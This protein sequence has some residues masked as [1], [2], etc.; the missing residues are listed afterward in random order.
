MGYHPGTG[1]YGAPYMGHS[2]HMPYGDGYATPHWDP[3]APPVA[4]PYQPSYPPPAQ[5]QAPSSHGDYRGGSA[6]GHGGSQ[7][8][9]PEDRHRQEGGEAHGSHASRARH[10]VQ[11]TTPS[12]AASRPPRAEADAV[13]TQASGQG[14]EDPDL[15]EEGAPGGDLEAGTRTERVDRMRERLMQVIADRGRE[16]EVLDKDSVSVSVDAAQF[17]PS[18]PSGNT[19]DVEPGQFSDEDEVGSLGR[20]SPVQ[21]YDGVQDDHEGE[22][23]TKKPRLSEGGYGLS[24]GPGTSGPIAEPRSSGTP[25]SRNPGNYSG[26]SGPVADLRN[27]GA[28]ESRNAGAPDSR[29]AGACSGVAGV[30]SFGVPDLRGS[31]VPELRDSA[32]GNFGARNR[33]SGAGFLDTQEPKQVSTPAEIANTKLALWNDRMKAVAAYHG[34]QSGPVEEVTLNPR[35]ASEGDVVV[36][37]EQ[38]TRVGLHRRVTQA[39]TEYQGLAEDL[40]KLKISPAAKNVN[41]S[42]LVPLGFPKFLEAADGTVKSDHLKNILS[43][44]SVTDDNQLK[45]KEVLFREVLAAQSLRSQVHDTMHCL[46]KEMPADDPARKCLLDC[47]QIMHLMTIKEVD[48][49]SSMLGSTIL[50]RRDMRLSKAKLT[51]EEKS[52]LRS[53]SFSSPLLMDNFHKEFV[54]DRLARRK[55]KHDDEVLNSQQQPPNFYLDLGGILQNQKM[56]L[57]PSK[58]K[59]GPKPHPKGAQGQ[60]PKSTPQSSS[61]GNAQAASQKKA[62]KRK[63]NWDDNKDNNNNKPDNKGRGSK[64]GRGRG[65]RGGRGAPPGGRPASK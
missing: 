18:P 46:I 37:K 63:G 7:G 24:G 27:S 48:S 61:Q 13:A 32:S 64:R 55:M 26:I 28:P 56:A 14:V 53:S 52:F 59:G 49:V 10:R 2:G 39:L 38:P 41:N 9:R 40:T 51:N 45:Q 42:F 43:E 11:R 58:A 4:P 1:G 23:P 16:S 54:D 34:V 30:G 8:Y 15:D 5:A 25:G 60:A 19:S 12:A 21:D 36:I 57:V 29:N 6:G 44:P 65:G 33:V 3:R 50:K 35:L 22:P 31:G 62:K 20:L 47:S 17:S